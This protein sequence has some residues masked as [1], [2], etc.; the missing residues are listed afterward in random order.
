MINGMNATPPDSATQNEKMV[1]RL[2]HAALFGQW[3]NMLRDASV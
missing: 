3:G 2:P 1:E